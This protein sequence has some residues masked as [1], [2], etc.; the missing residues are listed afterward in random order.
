LIDVSFIVLQEKRVRKELR[1]H[2][3]RAYCDSYIDFTYGMHDPED[4]DAIGRRDAVLRDRREDE[5][6][7]QQL[8]PPVVELD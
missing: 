1:R 2:L 4:H 7:E 8:R 3:D 5:E 6:E